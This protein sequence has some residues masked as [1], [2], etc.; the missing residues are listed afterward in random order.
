MRQK[1]NSL[2]HNTTL[3][4]HQGVIDFDKVVLAILFQIHRIKVKLDD[5]VGVCSQLPLD[6]GVGRIRAVR[7]A[8]G[9]DLPNV[10]G[11]CVF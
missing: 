11:L 10:I 5:I 7:E 2:F 9:L 8:R 6:E 1:T 4:G 3:N